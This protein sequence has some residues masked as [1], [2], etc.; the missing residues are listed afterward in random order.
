[1]KVLAHPVNRLNPT[2]SHPSFSYNKIQEGTKELH[3]LPGSLPSPQAAQLH[4]QATWGG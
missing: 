1:M 2:T 4:P 3:A